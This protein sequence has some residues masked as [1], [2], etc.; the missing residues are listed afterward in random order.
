MRTK[1]VDAMIDGARDL[2]MVMAESEALCRVCK[3]SE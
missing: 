1:A 3:T 2:F